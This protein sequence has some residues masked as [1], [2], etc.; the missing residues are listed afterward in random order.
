MMRVL[1]KS[2]GVK[3][4][5]FKNDLCEVSI[6]DLDANQRCSWHYHQYKWNQ[7]YVIFGCIE[8]A[9]EDGVSKVDKGHVFTTNPMQKHE[10]RTPYGKALVQE[11]MYVRYDCEDIIRESRGGP[12]PKCS[13]FGLGEK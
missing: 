12:I 5:L 3:T 4:E 11:V 8:I 10:F 1:H 2:W 6:L 13:P 9:T 7:F